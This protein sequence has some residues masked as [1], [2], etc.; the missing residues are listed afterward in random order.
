M[1]TRLGVPIFQSPILCM[2]IPEEMANL[3]HRCECIPRSSDVKHANKVALD[4]KLLRSSI[5]QRDKERAERATLVAQEKL[6]CTY[7]PLAT[8]IFT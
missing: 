8:Q 5:A 1:W 4:I 3:L 7:F 2:P 6:V